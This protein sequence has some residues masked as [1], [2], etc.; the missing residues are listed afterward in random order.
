M[1]WGLN[2]N[3]GDEIILTEQDYTSVMNTWQEVE[4]RYGV[5]LKWLALALPAET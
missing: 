3:I 5:V 1:I 2:Y 4:A